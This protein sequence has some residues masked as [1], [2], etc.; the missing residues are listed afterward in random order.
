MLEYK[1]N[2]RTLNASVFLPFVHKIWK[3]NYD[4]KKTGVSVL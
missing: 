3:G 4:I 1:V 2:D